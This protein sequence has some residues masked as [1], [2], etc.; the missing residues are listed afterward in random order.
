MALVLAGALVPSSILLGALALD[1]APPSPLWTGAALFR[2][3]LVV[4]GVY[5]GAAGLLPLWVRTPRTT[6]AT[7][8]P[9]WATATFLGILVVALAVRLSHL[10][11]GLWYDEI[12]VHVEYMG[13]SFGR[14]LT[15]YDSESQHFLFTILA[16]AAIAVLGEG[17]ASLRLPAALFGVASVAALYL[18]ARRVATEREALLSAALLAVSYHHVWFSQ[19]ARG[20]TALLF[21][22]LLSSWLFLRALDAGPPRLWVGYAVAVALGVFSH[23]TMLFAVLAHAAV[24]GLW[25]IRR[26]RRAGAPAW[27]GAVLGFGLAALLTFQLYALALPQ[28]VATIGMK[29]AVSDWTNPLWT[30]LELARGMTIGFAGNALAV[31][32]V[33]VFGVGCLSFARTTPA[34]VAFVVLPAAAAV[35]VVLAMGH[36]LWPRFFFFLMGFGVLIAVR[37]ALVVGTAGARVAGLGPPHAALA[38]T[39]LVLVLIGASATTVPRAWLP[40]QDYAGALTFIDSHR[41]PGDAVV[42]VGLASYPYGMFYRTGWPRADTVD[43]LN[44]IRVGARRTW[45]VYTLPV[46][47]ENTYPELMAAIREEFTVVRTFAGTLHGGAIYVCRADGSSSAVDAAAARGSRS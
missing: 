45:I 28:F 36:P 41:R 4:T 14:V 34:I 17:P 3:G 12:I 10:G 38:G 2:V 30:L 33:L 32:A 29:T 11:V 37:G 21:W 27:A 43:A 22:T 5:L 47:V 8:R 16:R 26:G 24:Y 44:A 1:T 20:Y 25:L 42:T 46:H 31:V 35:P 23:V 13:M 39:A 7:G 15:T 18:L 6:P 9:R 40:K 19:N